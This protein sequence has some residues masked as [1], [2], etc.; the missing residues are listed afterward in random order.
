VTVQ[1][2]ARPQLLALG[3]E[4][5]GGGNLLSG[6]LSGC[7]DCIK[8]LD[9]E[10][11]L[12]FMSEG[13]KRVMEVDDFEALKGCPWPDFWA[14]EGNAQALAAIVEARAGRA[15]R[16]QNAA[17]TAR[18]TPRHWDVQVTPI[19]NEKGDP[20]HILSISRDITEEWKARE[21]QNAAL[22]RQIFLTQ[23]LTHRVKNTLAT[24]LALA[25]QTFRGDERKIP[26]EAFLGR[27]KTMGDAYKILTDTSWGASAIKAVVEGAVAPYRTGIGRIEITGPHHDILPNQALVLALAINELSTNAMKYGALSV[28]DGKVDISWTV[29]DSL[30]FVWRETGGPVVT[31]PT[32]RGF[33]S[34]LIR[35]ILAGDF[36]GSVDLNYDPSGVI[37]RLAAPLVPP[38]N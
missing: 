9:L 7:G 21:A 18:G 15:A 2:T 11:R 17:N 32:R 35:T 22:E 19:L 36:K 4:L 23:E 37:C 30:Q 3:L 27:I 29:T 25:N 26:R 12:Q 38:A 33:G 16:F 10:G 34:V 1:N 24:V 6:I 5:D 14:G 13:G 20:T 8:V 28:P 31:T